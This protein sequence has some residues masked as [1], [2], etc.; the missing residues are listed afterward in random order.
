[1]MEIKPEVTDRIM[2][3]SNQVVAVRFNKNTNQI[4]TLSQDGTIFIW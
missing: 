1:M 3:H 4:F 2:T